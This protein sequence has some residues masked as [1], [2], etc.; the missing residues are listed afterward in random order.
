MFPTPDHLTLALVIATVLPLL[1][2]AINQLVQSKLIFGQW[3]LPSRV[4]PYLTTLGSFLTGCST[5]VASQAPF[6]ATGAAFFMMGI[7]GE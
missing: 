7:A 5:Y 1:V 3:P 2:G 6:N 4:L